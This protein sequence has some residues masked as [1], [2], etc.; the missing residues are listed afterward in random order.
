MPNR[1]R[2]VRWLVLAACALGVIGCASPVYDVTGKVTYNGSPLNKPDGQIVFVGPNGE[3]V[4][5]PIGADG[6]YSAAGVAGGSNRIAVYYPNAK[7]KAEKG[8]KL[9]PG[10]TPKALP[11]YLTPEK[12][13]SP[14]TSEL[15]ATVSKGCA[16]DADL[17]GPKIP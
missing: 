10:E 12:Y 5:A 8:G 16:Y 9:K 6:T 14:E 7:A 4:A 3:Q 13:A 17:T 11:K 2:R 1:F 15:T